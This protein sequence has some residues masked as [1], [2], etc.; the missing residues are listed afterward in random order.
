MR[1]IWLR[2]DYQQAA[3]KLHGKLPDASNVRRALRHEDT[4]LIA[5]DGKIAAVFLCNVISKKLQKR[6]YEVLKRVDELPRKRVD[7][8]GTKSLPQHRRKDGKWSRFL[9]VNEKVLGVVKKHGV[10]TGT[11]GYWNGRLTPLTKKHPRWLKRCKRLSRL[12]DKLYRKYLPVPYTKQLAA[13]PP[14]H[15]LFG[16]AF[17]TTYITKNWQ[18]CY[19][20]DGNLKGGMTCITPLGH[21]TGG[22]L[23]LLRW[24][25]AVPY[26]RGD[27]LIFNAEDLHG[28]LP[29]EGER[30]SAAFFCGGWV[31][32]CS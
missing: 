32:R 11:L 29:F 8:V 9:S 20:V 26:Q 16:T 24:R 15:Q 6:A 22:A 2:D 18:T 28:N 7:A 4:T 3:R 30:L 13:V 14:R 12:L 23:V 21:F 25:V 27:L 10:K 5:P 31:A 1:T 19:H 17:S